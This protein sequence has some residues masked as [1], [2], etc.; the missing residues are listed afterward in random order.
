MVPLILL[1]TCVSV[2]SSV[3]RLPV[4]PDSASPV[5]FMIG[6]WMYT[7]KRKEEAGDEEQGIAGDIGLGPAIQLATMSRAGD[8]TS[9]IF[10][11]MLF[12][13]EH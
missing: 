4:D 6:G 3:S 9:L 8:S 11:Q 5:L 13:I 7:E 1:F 12:T 2:T 10:L